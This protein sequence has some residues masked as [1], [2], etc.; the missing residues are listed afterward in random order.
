MK[1]YLVQHGDA[2]DKKLDAQRPLS[3]SGHDDV[4]NIAAFLTGRIRPSRVF[5][6]GKTRARQTAEVLGKF[7]GQDCEVETMAGLN[8]LDSV[9]SFV[10]KAENFGED[11]LIVGHLPFMAKL[12]ATMVSGSK[13]KNLVAFQPGSIVC[14][15]SENESEW[16]IEWMIRPELLR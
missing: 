7:L 5:H 14:L 15:A 3:A 1:L 8:P 4:V 9:T 2:V 10:E 16:R 11:T 13:D 12:V 6:S